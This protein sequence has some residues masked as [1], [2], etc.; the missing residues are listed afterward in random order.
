MGAQITPVKIRFI[1]W[2]SFYPLHLS[3][4][5]LVMAAF[6]WKVLFFF[7]FSLYIAS[8]LFPH[9]LCLRACQKQCTKWT[10]KAAGEW[11]EQTNPFYLL[12][13][14]SWGRVFF[15]YFC[16]NLLNGII[17]DCLSFRHL[18]NQHTRGWT[19]FIYIVVV[20]R[21]NASN[22]WMCVHCER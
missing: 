1:Q 9:T 7:E 5:S 4:V 17:L 14:W 8:I 12:T 21:S 19:M 13:S 18:N 22:K 2:I 15:R 20:V 10:G 16:E 3:I 6:V 11:L